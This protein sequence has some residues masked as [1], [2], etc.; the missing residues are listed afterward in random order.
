MPSIAFQIISP[1]PVVRSMTFAALIGA[2]IIAGPLST[3][4]AADT[5]PQSRAGAAATTAAK[6]ET[7]EQR[8]ASLHASLKITQAEEAKWGAVA[9][10]M[11]E[12]AAA[13]DRLVAES[14]TAPPRNMT[15]VDDLKTYQK[16]A[17]A[18]AEGLKNLISSFTALY[19]T[20][21][22]AQKKV[23]DQVFQ[24]AHQAAGTRGQ[25]G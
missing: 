17:E 21:P 10:S 24:S 7:V 22:D 8:I 5:A 11:R 19:E 15:A 16:F 20:M 4:N 12:N 14:R 25:T 13:M 6:G 23:A 3:A 2:A 9:Q 1:A 18:H